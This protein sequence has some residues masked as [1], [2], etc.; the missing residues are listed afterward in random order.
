MFRSQQNPFDD[1]VIKATDEN[2]TSE[3]WEYMMDAWEKVNSSG[4]NGS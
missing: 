4:E 3:N 1:V 2:L